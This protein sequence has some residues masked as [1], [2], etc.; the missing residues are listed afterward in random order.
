LSTGVFIL[1]PHAGME[2]VE[3]LPDV[4][5]VIVTDQNEVLISTGL[6]GRVQIIHAPSS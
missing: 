5:A 3:R 2:L 1:G 6:R 4:E